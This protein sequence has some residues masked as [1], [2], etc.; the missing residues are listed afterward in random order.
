M[1]VYTS[2][3][4]TVLGGKSSVS[5]SAA[6]LRA[7]RVEAPQRLPSASSPT[8]HIPKTVDLTKPRKITGLGLSKL[9]IEVGMSRQSVMWKLHRGLTPDQIRDEAGIKVKKKRITKH[10]DPIDIPL[11]S[12]VVATEEEEE[13]YE[14]VDEDGKPKKETRF[15]AETRKQV[16]LAN[17][18][19]I[20]VAQRR[21]EL[22]ARVNVANFLSS[23]FVA[24]RDRLMRLGPENQDAFAAAAGGVNAAAVGEAV[25]RKVREILEELANY[26]VPE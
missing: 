7:P 24:V 21:G 25:D 12:G 6:T 22:M 9:A 17:E 20:L 13:E 15:A 11:P 4:G 14:E 23:T 26:E 19:E 8:V 3:R 18:R 5:T 2:S 10:T 16:A 1:A